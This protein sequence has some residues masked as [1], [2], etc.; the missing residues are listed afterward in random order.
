VRCLVAVGNF[1]SCGKEIVISRPKRE[2]QGYFYVGLAEL[3]VG[4]GALKEKLARPNQS[5]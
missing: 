5:V 1:A 3:G 4:S 2:R